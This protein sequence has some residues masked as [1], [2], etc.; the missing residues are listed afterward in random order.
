VPDERSPR[1]NLSVHARSPLSRSS[2]ASQPRRVCDTAGAGAHAFVGS[3]RVEGL[4]EI[5]PAANTPSVPLRLTRNGQTLT[6]SVPQGT[7][8]GKLASG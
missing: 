8:R 5:S 2:Q 4:G 3:D 7:G 1:R 6:I